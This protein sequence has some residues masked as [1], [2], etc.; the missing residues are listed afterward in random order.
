M[1]VVYNT[2]DAVFC[3]NADKLIFCTMVC[4]CDSLTLFWAVW[5][6]VQTSACSGSRSVP[7]KTSVGDSREINAATSE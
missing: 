1:E 4:Y 6:C 7:K 2:D 3:H 5:P